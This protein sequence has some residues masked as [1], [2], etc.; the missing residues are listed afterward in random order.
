VHPG[1]YSC[2]P[3]L[4]LF[5]RKNHPRTLRAVV[6]RQQAEG[7]EPQEEESGEEAGR[8]TADSERNASIG[9]FLGPDA[10]LS[11]HCAS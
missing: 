1:S 4:R 2:W 7:Q 9:A 3:L 8:A 6:R 10:T 5:R 11:T